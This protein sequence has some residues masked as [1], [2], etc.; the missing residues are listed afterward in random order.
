[1]KGIYKFHWSCGRAG[2]LDGIF[3]ADSEQ[4]SSANGCSISFG[5]VLG[6]HSDIYG[7]LAAEDFQLISDNPEEVEMFERLNLETGHNPIALLL[8]YGQYEG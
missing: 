7:T 3:V 5:E 8:E 1:M 4:I 2:E 6:K